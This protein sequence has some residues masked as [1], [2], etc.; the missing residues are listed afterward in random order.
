V[1]KVTHIVLTPLQLYSTANIHRFPNAEICLSKRGWIHY[2][3]THEHPHDKRWNCISKETLTYLVVD[4]WERVR[5]LEDEDEIAPGIRTWWTGGHHRASLA[6][7]IDSTVGTVVVSDTFFT[8][9]NVEADHPIG[10]S[11]N[12]YEALAAHNR[13]RQVA[14]HIVPLYDPDVFVRYSDGLVAP[15]QP[16]D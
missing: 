7:E 13:A 2:H 8:Y 3:T 9:R 5:L 15:S 16:D 14:D 6:V 1:D 10:I 4:A 11:E 12:I